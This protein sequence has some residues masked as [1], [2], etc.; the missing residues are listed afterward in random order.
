M[1]KGSILDV[2]CVLESSL[3][4]VETLSFQVN[5]QLQVK[6]QHIKKNL[7]KIPV[8]KM[9]TIPRKSFLMESF[10][11]KELITYEIVGSTIELATLPK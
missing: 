2:C 4:I 3:V 11:A 9:W 1:A 7:K 6:F 10:L 8:V 5:S